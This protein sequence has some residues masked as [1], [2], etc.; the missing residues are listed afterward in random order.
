MIHSV[1][2]FSNEIDFPSLFLET[3]G[4]F[5]SLKIETETQFRL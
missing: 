4:A 1:S 5:Q 3:E 2:I